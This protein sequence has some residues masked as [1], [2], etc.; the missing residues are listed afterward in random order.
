MMIMR[1]LDN[2]GLDMIS[3]VSFFTEY[4][5]LVFKFDRSYNK[6]KVSSYLVTYW[7]MKIEIC[8]LKTTLRRCNM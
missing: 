5:N 1:R 6:K 4:V 3:I 7:Y 8:N 2:T